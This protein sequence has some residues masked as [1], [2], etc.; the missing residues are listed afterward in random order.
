MV[1]KTTEWFQY[2]IVHGI[3]ATNTYLQKIGIVDSDICTN[4]RCNAE[5]F[6]HLFWECEYVSQIWDSL[7][8]WM[9]E[10]FE[11][12]IPLNRIDVIFG[13]YY[14]NYNIF[15]KIICIV[16]RHIQRKRSR[17]E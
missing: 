10:K 13:R 4:S 3:L 12:D 5:T 11:L 6:F 15:N 8:V 9:K 16:K 1:G 2:W 14:K 17:K 7:L